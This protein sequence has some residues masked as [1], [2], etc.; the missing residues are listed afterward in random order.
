M[1]ESEPNWSLPEF[2]CEDDPVMVTM[3]AYEAREKQEQSNKARAL[4]IARDLRKR[5]QKLIEHAKKLEVIA[6]SRTEDDNL[7][8][9]RELLV[10]Y[11][12]G[13]GMPPE[14]PILVNGEYR[15]LDPAILEYYGVRDIG[16][17]DI[18]REYVGSSA[19]VS[20]AYLE[21][22][23]TFTEAFEALAVYR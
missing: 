14:I 1:S 6:S 5:A 23:K 7:D 22:V 18:L 20:E 16:D 11:I 21:H 2:F 4:V 3:D 17:E 10:A 13:E 12:D 9:H 15:Y 8:D 19:D